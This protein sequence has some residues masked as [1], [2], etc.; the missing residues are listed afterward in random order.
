MVIMASPDDSPKP[1][2]VIAEPGVARCR[3]YACRH[4]EPGNADERALHALRHA[5]FEEWLAEH[6]PAA[7]R[8]PAYRDMLRWSIEE[9]RVPTG[10]CKTC[11]GK[12]AH[13]VHLP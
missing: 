8:K 13:P 2:P 4:P 3:C 7:I 11:P 5:D 10:A 1:E 12:P 6:R 9:G